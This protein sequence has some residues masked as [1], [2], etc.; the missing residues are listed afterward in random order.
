MSFTSLRL[1]GWR[2]F[3][4]IDIDFHPRLTIITGANG[5]GKSTIL[6]ILASHFGW[7]HSLLA[8]PKLNK[9]GEKSFHNGVFENL[10]SL[11]HKIA[12]NE[13]R[14]NI[15]ELV[16][17]DSKSLI[18]LPRK[19]GI[20]YSLHIPQRISMNGINIDSHRPKPEYQPVTQIQANTADMKLFYRKYFNEYKQSGR[21]AN[22]IFSLKE[23]LIN[24]AIFGDGNK[25][26][27][28]N[29]VIQEEFEGFKKILGVCYLIVS[30]L[31]TLKL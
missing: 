11:F 19:T 31:K 30:A 12:N 27:Q 9:K 17:K 13:A 5:A 15:G 8:T 2:Q 23:A 18:S 26:L 22:P 1:E 16:Y 6:K 4:K 20:N 28:A 24:M 14:T 10:I 21:G 29:A 3:N 7:N 25:N